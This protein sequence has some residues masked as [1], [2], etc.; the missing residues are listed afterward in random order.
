VE[1]GN[2]CPAPDSNLGFSPAAFP[3]SSVRQHHTPLTE[4]I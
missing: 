2:P 1:L 3:A 4:K